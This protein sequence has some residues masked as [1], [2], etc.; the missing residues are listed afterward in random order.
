MTDI[1]DDF[2]GAGLTDTSVA[3]KEERANIGLPRSVTSV[4]RLYEF[5][6]LT[7]LQKVDGLNQGQGFA[8]VVDNTGVVGDGLH[9]YILWE[10]IST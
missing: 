3:N 4:S 10:E 1:R 5:T 2:D 8:I 6:D 7:M 9:G